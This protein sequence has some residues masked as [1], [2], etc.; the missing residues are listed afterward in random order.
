MLNKETFNILI[1]KMVYTNLFLFQITIFI[2]SF[3]MIV[4][5]QAKLD[6]SMIYSTDR[7]LLCISDWTVEMVLKYF[8]SFLKINWLN[9]IIS[10]LISK[11]KAIYC[12]K[13]IS[14]QISVPINLQTHLHLLMS[15]WILT[16]S[17][18]MKAMKI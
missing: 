7:S 12:W 1:T 14:I 13:F 5:N 17:I 9:L 4:F 3:F 16:N 18:I 15:I 6:C 2:Y 8:S 10:H 11:M